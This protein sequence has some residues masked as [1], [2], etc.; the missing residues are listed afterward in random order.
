MTWLLSGEMVRASDSWPGPALCMFEVFGRTGPPT[1]GGPPFWT[2]K[3]PS[4][5]TFILP[6][7]AVLT[8]EPEMLQP[9]AF[10]EHTMQQ[11]AT[12]AGAPAWTLFSMEL[13]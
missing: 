2:L 1:L 12:A 8:K 13:S 9:D 5:L 11:N 4:K 6:L 7:I 10:C 3:I